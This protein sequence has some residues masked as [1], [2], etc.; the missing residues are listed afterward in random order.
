[1]TF[2]QR[3]AA[4]V[5]IAVAL[6]VT[7]AATVAYLALRAQSRAEI[8]RS[9][10]D[11][12][13]DFR[14]QVV[15]D[16]PFGSVEFPP[17]PVGSDG[18]YAQLVSANGEVALPSGGT[19]TLPVDVEVLAVASGSAPGFTRD[20]DIEDLHLRVLTARATP[21]RSVAIMIA[22]SL[23]ETDQA[24]ARIRLLLLVIALAGVG[25]A[26]GLGWAVARSA[27]IPVARLSKAAD[28]IAATGDLHRRLP[29]G[30]D[31][32][33][34]L[35]AR[36]NGMLDALQSSL[37]AQ[38]A[39]VADASHEL[40][41]PLT[42]LRTNIE[43]FARARTLPAEERAQM[44]RDITAQIEGLSRLVNDL[45]DL[46]RGSEPDEHREDVRLDELVTRAVEQARLN[47]PG[48]RFDLRAEPVVV[49]AAPARVERAV[50]NLIDNAAKYGANGAAPVE[51][52]VDHGGVT[53]RDHGPGF[54]EGDMPRI[55]D[56]FY[57]G[58]AVRAVPGSGLGL[59]IAKQVADRHD[60]IL[61]A[62]NANPG[63]R[64]SLE[65]PPTQ[66]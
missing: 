21:D 12:L 40:R 45:I 61:H 42:S 15:V 60:W 20:V 36:F 10:N 13:A 55:F 3:L 58:A 4:S 65:I 38:R 59:A 26:A 18:G 43:V 7:A 51:I 54:A 50:S 34:R 64:I 32:L 11:R 23:A 30:D 37:D 53:V 49:E 16:A 66:T 52:V 19:F 25:G 24:L 5:A 29:S 14:R 46:A 41:T 27:L 47:H 17:P 28:E 22:R 31:E 57:R 44:L 2:R 63:A 33:G 6:S 1:M 39:L 35:G 56:R 62:E 48:T 9:L 8:D